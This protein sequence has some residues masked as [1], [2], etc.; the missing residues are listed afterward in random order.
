MAVHLVRC[1]IS[2]WTVPEGEC[3]ERMRGSGRRL[4]PK[5][6]RSIL[7]EDLQLSDLG[8]NRELGHDM[9][10]PESPS[11]LVSLATSAQARFILHSPTAPPVHPPLRHLRSLAPMG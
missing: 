5:L 8:I 3:A 6:P 7:A 4:Y 11:W 2:V 9:F 10:F 1:T